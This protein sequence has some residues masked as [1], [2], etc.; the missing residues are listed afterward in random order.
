MT[1]LKNAQSAARSYGN[2]ASPLRQ[3]R[4][5]S[6]P[7]RTYQPR[8]QPYTEKMTRKK[9]YENNVSFKTEFKTEKRRVGITD[10]EPIR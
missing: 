8:E 4:S 1:N 3:S 9:S 5:R 6:P 10:Y 7:R 2:H